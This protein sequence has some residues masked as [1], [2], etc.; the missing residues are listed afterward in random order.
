MTARE[1]RAGLAI[2]RAVDVAIVEDAWRHYHQWV[3]EE[4]SKVA[5][6]QSPKRAALLAFQRALVRSG[7]LADPVRRLL[8]ELEVD[9]TGTLQVMVNGWK[10]AARTPFILLR[11][12]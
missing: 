1:L 2:D 4:L 7:H 12:N 8:E 6:G 9:S 5:K 11:R 3:V 10:M